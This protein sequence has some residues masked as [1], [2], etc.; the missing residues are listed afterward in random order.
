MS[1]SG[2]DD[3][4]LV[5]LFRMAERSMRVGDRIGDY[6]LLSEL[7]RGG[8]GVVYEARAQNI[9]YHVALKVLREGRCAS[10]DRAQLFLRA[11]EA[12][13]QLQ[14][15]HIIPILH[16]GSHQGEP[17]FTMRR[18][19]GASLAHRL[20][21][22]VKL[23]EQELWSASATTWYGDAALVAIVAR[24]VH[25]AHQHGT[26]HRDLKPANILLDRA[27][28]PY[29]ADFGLAQRLDRAAST[30]SKTVMGTLQYMP[31]E[32]ARAEKLTVTAD[33]YSLGAI[34]YEMLTGSS[35]FDDAPPH[36]LIQRVTSDEPVRRPRELDRRIPKHL[37]TICLKCLNKSAP[38]R[39][40]SALALADDLESVCAGRPPSVPPP[41]R[42]GRAVHWIRRNPGRAS[43]AARA[44][45]IVVS[46]LAAISYL[47][48]YSARAERAALETNAFIA[49]G[50]AGA[51]LFQLR[52]YA[53]R[54]LQV[55][56]K[57]EVV[58]LASE[59]A[60][61]M[62]RPRVLDALHDE[63]MTVFVVSVSGRIRS[64]RPLSGRD[65]FSRS[66]EFRDYFR[67]ARLL[68]QKGVRGAYVAHAFR[69]ES[70][71]K[72]TFGVSAPLFDRERWVGAL[73]AV[74]PADSVFGKV[75]MH[76]AGSG[77]VMALLGPRDVDRGAAP[78]RAERFVFL[79]HDGLRSG[80]EVLATRAPAL[81]AAFDH[82]SAPGEQFSLKYV[83]PHQETYYEDPVRGFDGTWLAAFA[84]VGGTGYVMAVQ[85][86]RPDLLAAMRR[87]SARFLSE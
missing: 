49:S 7:G 82:A 3:T 32:Q 42:V 56:S 14:H 39:Y 61:P 38:E 55:A 70:D 15:P 68:G 80:E 30:V 27:G 11:A 50:Q 5:Q 73:V 6:Q 44:F 36:E 66:F 78:T 59:V 10:E 65:V 9:D 58:A 69:S 71:D 79:V 23:R 12:A 48:D 52:E 45:A 18:I 20:A 35:L 54:V 25:Y 31:P 1:E 74:I 17:F 51:A 34:L 86:P 62:E 26:L 53:D 57:T 60:E 41:S 47:W 40:Q 29:V 13:A 81:A 77:R 83:R 87:F 24:A 67:G 22:R 37:E 28:T 21:D 43:R 19:D 75:R 8:E 64:L 76:D 84:P 4:N 85:S 72:L 33:V 63:F 2:S 46:V 16:V